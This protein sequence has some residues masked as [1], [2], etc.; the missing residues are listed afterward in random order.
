MK[1][2]ILIIEDDPGMRLGMSHYLSTAGYNVSEAFSGEEAIERLNKERFD[3]VITDLR[4]P[5][6]D[7]LSILRHVKSISSDTGVIIIT[8]FAEVKTAV[9]A[10]K[11]GAFDYL[12]KPF[13]NEELLIVIEK[14]LKF[15]QLETEV[16]RLRRTVEERNVLNRLIG[17]SPGMRDVIDRIEAIAKTDVP[18]LI[19]GETGTG[20]ELVANEIHNRSL[21]KD[22]P[23]IKINCAA[24][25]ESLFESE[26]FGHEKGAFTGATESKKGRFELAN[27]GTI[28]FDEIGDMPLSLQ[29]KLLRVLEDQT[30]TRLG[31]R[32]SIKVD[33]RCIY[34]TSKNLKQLVGED[35]FR[36]DLYYRINVVPINIP[37]LRERR[38]DIPSLIEHFLQHFK[39]KYSRSDITISS[40]AYETLLSY[41][42]PGNVRE[43]KHAIERAVLLSK[44][45]IIH[46]ENLPEEF[47]QS[48]GIEERCIHQNRPLPDCLELF[49]KRLITNTLKETGGKRI[50][51]AKRLGISRKALWKKIKAYKIDIP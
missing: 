50:E 40:S 48:S 51:A 38:E 8:A 4:L 10:I 19:Q 46:V 13:S 41:N 34:A 1:E 12:S 35:K 47:D 2:K 36:E 6:Q 26:L 32:Q 28:F 24:I 7:G 29:A 9:Q 31:G 15:R 33:V 23:F 43:L 22:G 27:G 11:E 44:N 45:G 20:K 49:E 30:I 42:Y 37:P 3:V 39:E 17:L 16:V 5:G 18:V 21:R 25:P 14:F